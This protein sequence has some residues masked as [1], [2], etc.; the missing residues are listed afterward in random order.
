MSREWI[1]HI[2]VK[3]VLFEGDKIVIRGKDYI[4]GEP[5]Y[6]DGGIETSIIRISPKERSVTMHSKKYGNFQMCNISSA[7]EFWAKIDEMFYVF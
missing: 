2:D 5:L 6:S 7:E 4:L 1:E 3:G